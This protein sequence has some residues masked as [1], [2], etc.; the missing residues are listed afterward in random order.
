MESAQINAMNI[1]QRLNEV[2]KDVSYLRKEK[3]VTGAG[4]YKVITHDQV[5]G[6]IRE[7]L[8]NHGIM[9]VPR[10]VSS[11]T[12]D[13]GTTTAKGIPIIR[14][15]PWFELDFVNIDEPSEKVTVPIE[16]HALDQGDKA[17]G[18]AISYATKYAMLKLFSI[19]SGEDEEDRPE[20]KAAKG[21]INLKESARSIARDASKDL[22]KEQQ[23]KVQQV[24]STVIDC[25]EA[26]MIGEACDAIDEAKF[27]IE[28]KLG[29]W[30]EL[31]SKQRSAITKENERRRA[32]TKTTQA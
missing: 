4:T 5:T 29:L 24:L 26:G 27:E 30:A 21:G 14:Y 20:I 18:K 25:I 16:A 32:A 6:E 7:S 23:F 17:P 2:R 19:E 22:T 13:T 9:I 28:E 11:K 12:V 31:D 1:Y 3:E 15:E 8:I 10:L